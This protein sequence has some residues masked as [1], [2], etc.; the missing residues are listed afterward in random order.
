M[1]NT[2]RIAKNT[3][4]LYFRQILIMGVSLY[5]V[6]VVL[7]VL[8]AEDYGIYNVVAGV[9]SMFSFLSGAMATASQRYFSF[10]LGKNDYE[11]L[12]KTFSVTLCIYLLLILLV[13]VLAETV[14]LWFVY[15][16]LVIP[17][18]R[19]HAAKWIYQFSIFSFVITLITTPYMA[20]IIAHENMNVYAYV[21]IVEAILKLVIV[22][23][24]QKLSYDKL[25]VYGFLLCAVG[26]INASLYRGFCK[27][28]YEECRFKPVWNMKMFQEICGF[29]GWSLF[30][31]FTTVVRT[32]ALT[33][34]I[35][36]FFNPVVVA[37]RAISNQ[38]SNTL[39]VFS[40][41]FNTSL[42]APII[43]EYAS[44]NNERMFS[45]IFNG[46]KMTFFLMWI[47]ALPLCLRM[48]YVLT[49]WLK[50]LPEYVVVFT[51]LSVIEVLIVSISLPIA[52]AA[53]APGKMKTYELVLGTL[54]LTIFVV[55]LIWIKYYNGQAI[56]IF[57]TAIIINIA[58]FVIRLL[59][60]RTLINLPLRMF[61]VN[62]ILPVF[63][64]FIISVIPSYYLNKVLPQ[65][66]ISLTLIV[67]ITL[68][69]STTLMFFMGISKD[70]RL[71]IVNKIRSKIS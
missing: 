46:C 20:S 43:K 65:N 50:Q 61:I 12:K 13:V 39:N 25:V 27:K 49:L 33:I 36:Q 51:I 15:N 21:S 48:E 4:M 41:N 34:L 60:I 23:I 14:G 2:K 26:F 68:F 6:R 42:Y 11:Q 47:F 63:A 17:P 38:V 18:E 40:S 70:Q 59:I 16:K 10:D 55:S 7:E 32:Q 22:F 52:T 67:I 37:A 1:S 30:G 31:A 24:L 3:L 71:R 62:V 8:G 45:L 66:F 5:T 69:L 54:Q 35:N 56:V 9:V 44:N 57:Y 19:L 58:M 28:H 64:I 53:R 29:T